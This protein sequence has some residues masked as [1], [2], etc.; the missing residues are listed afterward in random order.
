MAADLH[1]QLGNKAFQSGQYTLAIEH[2]SAALADGGAAPHALCTNRALSFLALHQPVEA[3]RDALRSVE[4]NSDWKKGHFCAGRALL[5]L[6]LPTA[7]LEH[8]ARSDAAD[9]GVAREIT[10]AQLAQRG[11]AEPRASSPSKS[12]S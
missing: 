9:A 6:G 11:T 8:L 12:P 10:A 3:L 1:K 5:A 2:Y 7:A 4:L